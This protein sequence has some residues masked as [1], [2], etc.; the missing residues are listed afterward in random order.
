MGL[1]CSQLVTIRPYLETAIQDID[2]LCTRLDHN[3]DAERRLTGYWGPFFEW[4][5]FD[6]WA[7]DRW[8]DEGGSASDAPAVDW[9][10]DV[11]IWGSFSMRIGT[12]G[13]IG[14]SSVE[15]A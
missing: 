11:P 13:Q 2:N 12:R 3:E 14:E 7:V 6:R 1:S 9:C 10:A 15:L 4:H 8:E 5:E